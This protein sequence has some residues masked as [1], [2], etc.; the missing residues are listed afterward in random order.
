MP[1][2]SV[3]I[4]CYNVYRNGER[5]ERWLRE[6]VE[7]VLSQSFEDLELLLVDDGSDD[8][9]V[10]LLREYIEDPRVRLIRQENQG[11]PG[12]RN[13]GLVEGAGEY[14]GFL[15]QDDIWKPNKLEVQLDTLTETQTDIVHS[16]VQNINGAG[17]TVGFRHE[18]PPPQPSDPE[19]YVSALFQDN[20]VCIQSVLCHRS[21]L[22][23]RRFNPQFSIACDIDMWLRIA[24]EHDFS[25][26]DEC[27]VK[28]RYHNTNISSNFN[29]SS[30]ELLKVLENAV[31]RYPFLEELYNTRASEVHYGSGNRA[32]RDGNLSKARTAFRNAIIL[33]P[34][35]VR[36]YYGLLA[37]LCGTNIGERLLD[38]GRLLRAV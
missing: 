7:S 31:E 36:A 8:G 19:E 12:A 16:N 2:V 30:A 14:Y 4:P 22:E 37:S 27:L 34:Y 13:T 10:A 38:F 21:V 28:K 17:E 18:E 24:G 3:S 35:N 11:Y 32:L 1:E 9:T 26:V 33:D 5:G 20:F 23:N 15:S 25:Y 6:A 29:Q